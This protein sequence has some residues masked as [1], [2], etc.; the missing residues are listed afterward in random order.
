MNRMRIRLA[1]LA[2]LAAAPALADIPPQPGQMERAASA[3]V[4]AAGFP[5]PD[6]AEF[7]E[8]TE[9]DQAIIRERGR[10]LQRL[11]CGSGK[12]FLVSPFVR[13]PMNVPR[14]QEVTPPPPLVLPAP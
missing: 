11:R 10:Q 12:S 6:P 1:A 13:V 4:R 9:R 14:G 2:L 7:Q 3:R 5:C 8:L